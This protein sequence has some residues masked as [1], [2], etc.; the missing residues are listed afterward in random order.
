M[1]EDITHNGVAALDRH[2]IV[3]EGAT[4]VVY[5]EITLGTYDANNDGAGNAFDPTFEYGFGRIGIVTVHVVGAGYV[6]QYDYDNRSIRVYQQANDGTG[7]AGDPLVEVPQ[8]E[9]LNIDI[10]V[11]VRGTGA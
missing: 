11:E 1:A 10:R 3:A 9:T 6:A 7:T 2:D 5:D 8:G 4:R